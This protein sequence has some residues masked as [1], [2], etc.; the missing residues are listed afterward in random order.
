MSLISHSK[1][2]FMQFK[3]PLQ[4]LR[5]LDITLHI[6]FRSRIKCFVQGPTYFPLLQHTLGLFPLLCGAPQTRC[7]TES[8]LP[9]E[10]PIY[11]SLAM[12]GWQS[13]LG[14]RPQAHTHPC[15]PLALTSGQEVAVPPW[16]KT[17]CDPPWAFWWH[18][19]GSFWNSLQCCSQ[20]GCYC[21]HF[22]SWES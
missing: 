3:V 10:L 17:W 22:C 9:S 16:R 20:W 6:F 11:V 8:S 12:A 14:D 19:W 4:G 5:T 1:F 13:S 7:N 2:L 21:Y 15:V 18:L